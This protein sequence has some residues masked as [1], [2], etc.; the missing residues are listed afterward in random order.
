MKLNKPVDGMAAAPGGG[1][2]W[3]VASDGGI[4]SFGSARFQGSLPSLGISD[5]TSR[6]LLATAD[7]GGYLIVCGDGTADDAGDA[8]Q[9]GDVQSAV[10]GYSGTVVGA[11]SVPG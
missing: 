6:T 5:D 10:P 4:F 2:Y 8:P 11:A 3:L 7:G 1:G 9:F